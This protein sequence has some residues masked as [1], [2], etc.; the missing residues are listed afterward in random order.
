M[1]AEIDVVHDDGAIVNINVTPLVDIVL[2]L[3]VVLMVSARVVASE[4]LPLDLPKASTTS[5]TSTAFVVSVDVDGRV[6][7]DGKAAQPGDLSRRARQAREREPEL[8]AIV[9][10]SRRVAHG[11]VVSV[12]DELR[13]AGVSRIAFA[14]ERVP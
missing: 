2:V 5:A 7:I 1:S 9:H 3:L 6:T 14:A 10:A 4:G 13:S 8:R 12:L 11:E